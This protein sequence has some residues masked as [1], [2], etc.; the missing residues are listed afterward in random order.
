MQEFFLKCYLNSIF[1]KNCVKGS[2]HELGGKISILL[3]HKF[4]NEKNEYI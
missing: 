2:K 4:V 3:F 1:F